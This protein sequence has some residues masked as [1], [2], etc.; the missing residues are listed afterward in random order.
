MRAGALDAGRPDLIPGAAELDWFRHRPAGLL[1]A[2]APR[3]GGDVRSRRESRTARG[4]EFQFDLIE[5]RTYSVHRM[6]TSSAKPSATV[7]ENGPVRA[8]VA[9]WSLPS[10]I[11]P[12]RT[13]CI[14]DRES[15]PQAAATWGISG[16]QKEPYLAEART[17]RACR[18]TNRTEGSQADSLAE[19]VGFEPT[20]RE[21]REPDFESGAF[22]HSAISPRST[23]QK[24]LGFR[25]A[26]ILA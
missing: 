19:R 11:R 24:P 14:A 6:S 2:T 10:N 21:T 1:T 18:P 12:D 9:L 4:R 16:L 13:D 22:D 15:G 5:V 25:K 17:V 3:S 7:L 23:F 8:A 26:R 20:S